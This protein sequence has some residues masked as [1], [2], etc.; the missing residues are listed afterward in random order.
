[1]VSILQR[2]ANLCCIISKSAF[3]YSDEAKGAWQK[4]KTVTK[5]FHNMGLSADPNATLA[6]PTSKATR[7]QLLKNPVANGDPIK[8]ME[9][10]MG[11]KKKKK[12][13]ANKPKPPHSEVAEKLEENANALR[14][15][16]FRFSKGQAELIGYYLDKYQLDYK[17]M[18]RDTKN[19]YQETWKQLRSKIRRFLEIPEHVDAYLKERNMERLT[20]EEPDSDSD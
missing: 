10:Q 16:G 15:S 17:K 18:V 3:Y 6:I 12:K 14:E 13:K 1:M 19:Y 11:D 8:L 9:A 5:N 7:V 2:I 4:H 20:L